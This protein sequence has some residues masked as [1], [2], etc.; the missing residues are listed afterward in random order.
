GLERRRIPR[1]SKPFDATLNQLID[2][3]A[4][5][6]ARFLCERLGVPFG[7]VEVLDTDLSTTLQADKVFRMGGDRPGLLH[8][9]L[10]SGGR[11]GLPH[12]LLRYKV[13]P[14]HRYELPVHSVINLLRKQVNPTDVTGQWQRVDL[15]GRPHL[16]FCYTV[17]RLW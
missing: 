13:L 3:H 4:A 5:D 8:L 14:G 15:D 17:L 7:P 2:D 6:W 16:E 10:E 9:E 11:L 12:D 1:T